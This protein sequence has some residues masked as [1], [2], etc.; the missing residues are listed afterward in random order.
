MSY[1]TTSLGLKL[2]V[3]GSGQAFETAVVNNNLQLLEN[4]IEDD[5]TRLTTIEGYGRPVVAKSLSAATPNLPDFSTT[6]RE[7]GEISFTT[8]PGHRYLC[9]V[10]VQGGQISNNGIPTLNMAWANATN[11]NAAGT[12]TGTAMARVYS[13]P[14]TLVAGGIA[15]QGSGLDS[16]VA[17]AATTFFKLQGS[18]TAAAAR[19]QWA[20]AIYDMGAI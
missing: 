17:T 1:T 11:T 14:M 2:A 20:F 7:G 6:N 19:F 15:V 10:S 12:Q 13:S 8:I 18:S 16:F 4:G 5:R 3:P 9:M